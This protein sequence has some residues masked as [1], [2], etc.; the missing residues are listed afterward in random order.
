MR[1]TLLLWR[2]NTMGNLASYLFPLLATC[3]SCRS[4]LLFLILTCSFSEVLCYSESESLNCRFREIKMLSCRTALL[5]SMSSPQPNYLESIIN[6]VVAHLQDRTVNM[7][8]RWMHIFPL[9][10][11]PAAHHSSSQHRHGR[12]EEM[13]DFEMW[14]QPT[15]WLTCV[16]FNQMKCKRW[17]PVSD[18]AEWNTALNDCSE[19][20]IKQYDGNVPLP[21]KMKENTQV[22]ILLQ[23]DCIQLITGNKYCRL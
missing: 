18:G 19:V 5:L 16:K 20:V 6:P 14:N 21:A 2:S 1:S 12:E 22:W 8:W 10:N 7:C 23:C 13:L 15:T 11:S 3:K 17:R 9:L 4:F